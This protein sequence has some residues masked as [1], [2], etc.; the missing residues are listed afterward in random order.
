MELQGLDR[1]VHAETA[2][3]HGGGFGS[4]NRSF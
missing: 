2:Y 1:A 4:S 3:E